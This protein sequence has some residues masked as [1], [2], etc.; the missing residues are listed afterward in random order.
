MCTYAQL[1]FS[2]IDKAS[3]EITIINALHFCKAF[4]KMDV[5]ENSLRNSSVFI[6]NTF[7]NPTVYYT[8]EIS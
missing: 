5:Y 4:D 1:H 3:I 6:Q 2:V 7:W 8:H